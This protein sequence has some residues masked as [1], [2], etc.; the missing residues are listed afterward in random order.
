M[1]RSRREKLATRARDT[2]CKERGALTVVNINKLYDFESPSGSKVRLLDLF[3]G[4]Q[5]LI[6]HDFMFSPEDNEG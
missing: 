1:A 2:L 4:R 5:Q 3:E 6:V